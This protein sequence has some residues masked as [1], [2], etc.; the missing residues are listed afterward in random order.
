M[1]SALRLAVAACLSAGLLAAAA[2]RH[3]P[4]P[5]PRPRLLFVGLDGASWKVINYQRPLIG[6]AGY[7]INIKVS[8]G[9]AD[10]VLIANS[11]FFRSQGVALP[12]ELG[13]YAVVTCTG[14]RASS[15]AAALATAVPSKNLGFCVPHR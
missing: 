3:E 15:A 7:Y 12:F 6:R 14:A 8:T 9:S 13:A 1:R 2:C 11:S 5:P 10:E 4:A